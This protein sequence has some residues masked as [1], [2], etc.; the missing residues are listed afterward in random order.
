MI[1]KKI[2]TLPALLKFINKHRREKQKIVFT[3]GCFD[4]LHRGHVEY[5]ET[6]KK[7]G[8]ILIVGLNSDSSVKIIKGSKRP[9]N[10]QNDRAAV[11][12][13]L[14]SVDYVVFFDQTTPLEII[15]KIRPHVLVK[16]SDW[17]IKDIVGAN[18]L[19]KYGGKIARIKFLNGYSTTNIIKKAAKK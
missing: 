7:Q 2:K 3:N 15:K 6:A 14:E 18:L 17:K 19:K 12:A 11:I 10:P 4:I 16:G 8:D 9:I 1:K 13:A 5:L